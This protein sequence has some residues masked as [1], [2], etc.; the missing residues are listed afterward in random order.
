[1]A[2]APWS[3]TSRLMFLF[4]VTVWG[5][6]YLFVDLG[7]H[8]ASPLWLATI[9]AGVGALATLAIASGRGAWGTLDARGRRDALLLGIPNTALF[10]GLWFPAAREVLPGTA[11]I[12]IYT[13][14]LWV[15][16]LSAPVLGHALHRRHWVAI[17]VGFAGVALIS[18]VWAL[19]NGSLSPIPILELLGASV[20]WA[21]GTV[22]FQ[23]RFHRSEMLEANT[24][25]VIG[26]ATVLLAVTL[27]V[28]P[29]PLPT[30]SPD[31][32]FTALW[33]GVLGTAVA[34]SL[35]FTLL[36]GTRA[37]KLSAYVFLV[38]VVALGASAVI[39][40]E[41]LSP[42]QLAGVALVLVGIYAISSAPEAGPQVPSS[43]PAT[44]E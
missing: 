10:F 39:Y 36:G 38:P 22:L 30:S 43:V 34:Y 26:G 27:A 15:A 5:F 28:G 14:P 12:L 2:G 16:L 41:R 4:I 3:G 32:W 44:P 1:M 33:L 35:W 40:S 42:L 37:A 8:Y 17:G 6:N 31:L 25:Q 9:R 23:R 29:T 20:S 11:A 24:F 19:S 7:L 18:Q 21:V 13:F